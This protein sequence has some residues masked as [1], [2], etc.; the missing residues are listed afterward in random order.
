MCDGAHVVTLS[1]TGN[2]C[3]QYA[4]WHARIAMDPLLAYQLEVF[5]YVQRPSDC[6]KP[7]SRLNHFNQATT[8][9]RNCALLRNANVIP[10]NHVSARACLSEQFFDIQQS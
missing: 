6:L 3:E 4:L 9:C 5:L 7:S 1:D 10:R 8:D 2:A